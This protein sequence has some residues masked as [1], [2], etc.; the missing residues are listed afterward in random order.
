MV[1]AFVDDRKS[2]RDF[3]AGLFHGMTLEEAVEHAE[4]NVPKFD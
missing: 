2:G 4:K 3:A 1:G